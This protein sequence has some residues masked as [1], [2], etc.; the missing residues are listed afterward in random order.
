MMLSSAGRRG[1][2]AKCEEL[3]ITAYLL[4]PIRQSDL[5]KAILLVMGMNTLPK[6]EGR[7]VTRHTIREARKHLHILLVEDNPVN[8]KLASRMLENWG[9]T[10]V[11]AND[12][13]QGVDR[14]EKGD[15]VFD[16]VLMDVQMPVMGGYEATAIIREWEKIHGGH[17]P[18][19]AMT[20]YAMKGDREK[21]LEAGMDDYVS[22]P[23]NKEI[24]FD[25]IEGVIVKSACD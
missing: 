25:V 14:L 6:G 19:V 3:G 22:K 20:A 12:G 16:L 18:I 17:I 8:Q 2:G 15:E 5:Q 21:T 23:I 24:L 13:R 10:V 7:L 4:K 1:D 11:L 9:H